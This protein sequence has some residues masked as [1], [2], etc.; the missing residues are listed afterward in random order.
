MTPYATYTLPLNKQ[1]VPNVH[2]SGI[3]GFFF[4]R[5]G[6][7]T[8]LG[9]GSAVSCRARLTD[10]MNSFYGHRTQNYMHKFVMANGGLQYL[11]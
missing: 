6:K 2:D 7:D 10:H 4:N 9:L 5:P 11:K 1:V 3:Y 8:D